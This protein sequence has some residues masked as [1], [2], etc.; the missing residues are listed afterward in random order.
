MLCEAFG[1]KEAQVSMIMCHIHSTMEEYFSI[2]EFN[3]RE[4][5]IKID[6]GGL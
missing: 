6:M 3:M 4:K 2:I 1:R 5:V